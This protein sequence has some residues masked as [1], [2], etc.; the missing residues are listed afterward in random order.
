MPL[1][2]PD[3]I[4]DS[5]EEDMNKR[6]DKMAQA[7]LA[8]KEKVTGADNERWRT[9]WDFYIGGENHW[10]GY[11]GALTGHQQ[12]TYNRIGRNIELAEALIEE[13]HIG[14]ELQPREPGDE[15]Q[16]TLLD[17]GRVALFDKEYNQAA[18]RKASKFARVLGVGYIK[19][20][21]DPTLTD[22]LGDVRLSMVPSE[23]VFIE[24]GALDIES[25]RWYYTKRS[26]ARAEAEA[27]FGDLDFAAPGTKPEPIGERED[28]PST[29]VRE[30]TNM[31]DTDGSALSTNTALLPGAAFFDQGDKQELDVEDWWLR[32]D[33]KKYPNGRHII[34]VGK[35]IVA[36]EN[37]KYDHG[38]WPMV[39][40]WDVE[41]PRTPY[42]DCAARQ[43]I[44]MQRD[45]NLTISLIALS[46]HLNTAS[47]WVVYTQTGIPIT[48]LQRQGNKAGGVLMCSR[49]GFEPK[50]MHT[51][52]IQQDL[53]NW[54]ATLTD[55]ID[56]AMRIQDVIPPG[57][58][59]FPASG[60]VVRELRESQLVE[61]RQKAAN[62][63]RMMKR[64][65][66]LAANLMQQYYT[67]DRWVRIVGPLPKALAG[68]EDP[69]THKPIAREDA[70]G[71]AYWVKMS[72]DGVKHG[73]DVRTIEATWEPLSRQAQVD[74]LIKLYELDQGKT[75]TIGDILEI[76]LSGPQGERL[77]QRIRANAEAAQAQAAP[78]AAGQPGMPPGQP[79]QQG[80]M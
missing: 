35:R 58:R 38:E 69:N 14:A 20:G 59:G 56:K 29:E 64:I 9:L 47:P 79:P 15:V 68:L 62:K 80:G 18:I 72:P 65:V 43:A 19:V 24:P 16:A 44:E 76:E 5:F 53:F 13:M 70:S 48:V 74:K 23:C 55:N 1:K 25:C 32:D 61:I 51:Q 4:T 50:R 17:I 77:T 34:R 41:D 46:V 31:V 21:W 66:W 2:R 71:K 42:G 52:P 39:E 57:A 75:F 40:I 49:P 12:F 26:M 30:Y 54:A 78:P 11:P 10:K 27:R 67:P 63:A 7:A 73:F 6:L 22:N 45:L 28:S 8:E 36:D 3:H 33:P 37:S 60:E